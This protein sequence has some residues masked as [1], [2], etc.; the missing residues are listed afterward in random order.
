MPDQVDLSLFGHDVGDLLLVHP[1]V[2]QGSH[3]VRQAGRIEQNRHRFRLL[4]THHQH[5]PEFFRILLYYSFTIF[6]S[7]T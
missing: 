3:C 6:C 2:V 1:Q 7:Q 4:P 5:F